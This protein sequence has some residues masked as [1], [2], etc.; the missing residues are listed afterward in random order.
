MERGKRTKEE[1]FHRERNELREGEVDGHLFQE[2]LL[3]MG[4]GVGVG[5]VL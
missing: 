5:G 1:R 2:L 3:V 4:R